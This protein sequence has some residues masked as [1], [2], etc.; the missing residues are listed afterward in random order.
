MCRPL[1][2]LLDLEGGGNKVR[3]IAASCIRSAPQLGEDGRDGEDEI[4]EVCAFVAEH[5]I[6]W[7]PG[8][9]SLHVLFHG[10]PWR[11]FGMS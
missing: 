11:A 9:H 8:A 6:I 2:L 5:G 3:T 4:I 1:L 7:V 10:V